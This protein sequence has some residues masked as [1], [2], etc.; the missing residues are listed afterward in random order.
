MDEFDRN[1]RLALG[2]F[3]VWMAFIMGSVGTA[4]FILGR[5]AGVW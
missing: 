2:F 5:W 1:R 3:A 4:L